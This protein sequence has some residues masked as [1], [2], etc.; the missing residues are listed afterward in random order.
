M[1]GGLCHFSREFPDKVAEL[2]GFEEF[3]RIAGMRLSRRFREETLTDI[4]MGGLLPFHPHLIPH[5]D[6]A[7]NERITGHD[8]E[9][10]FVSIRPGGRNRYLRLHLQAKRATA[11]K[12]GKHWRYQ[13]LDYREGGQA[14]S[15]VTEARNIG[16]HCVPLYLLYH[17]QQVLAPRSGGLPA[18]DGV[19][20]MLAPAVAEAVAGGCRWPTRKVDYWRRHFMPLSDLLC[21]PLGADSTQSIAAI[22]VQLRMP[23]MVAAGI[24]PDLIASRLERRRCALRE[25]WTELDRSLDDEPIEASDEVPPATMQL[26]QGRGKNPSDRDRGAPSRAIFVS[27]QDGDRRW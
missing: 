7:S 12:S 22:Q 6:F 10:E 4:L 19:N 24:S 1:M 8:I 27:R 11:T 26:I 16:G 25:M 2:L 23:V 13:E 15:L 20:V 17:P 9:W 14:E 3:K 18:V 21:C 5:I